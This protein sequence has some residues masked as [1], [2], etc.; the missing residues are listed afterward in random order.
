MEKP[1]LDKRQKKKRRH[2]LAFRLEH[3]RIKG[4]NRKKPGIEKKKK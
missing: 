1:L 4:K 3:K 2:N